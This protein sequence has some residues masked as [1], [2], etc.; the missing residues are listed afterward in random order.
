MMET[1]MDDNPFTEDDPFADVV[2][3]IDD[4]ERAK[5]SAADTERKRKEEFLLTYRE[6]L[7]IVDKCFA[8]AVNSTSIRKKLG[9]EFDIVTHTPREDARELVIM[10]G[11]TLRC[12]LAF[13]PLSS[14]DGICCLYG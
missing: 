12:T 14:L 5:K 8:D 4:A 1:M 11:R 9:D 6:R 3:A 13:A 10:G 7:R 2:K